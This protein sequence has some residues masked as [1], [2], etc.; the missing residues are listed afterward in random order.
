MPRVV[1]SFGDRGR[2]EEIDRLWAEIDALKKAPQ[3]TKSEKKT[4]AATNFLVGTE[5]EVRQSDQAVDTMTGVLEFD[6]AD[7]FS[8][9]QTADA[10]K[11]NVAPSLSGAAGGDLTGT[12]PNPTL[13]AIGTASGPIGDATHVAAVTKDAKGRVTGLSSVAISGVTPGGSAG[14]D[15]TG[16]YPNPALTTSGVSAGTYGDATNVPRV[17]FD[18][19]GRATSVSNIAISAGSGGYAYHVQMIVAN[20]ILTSDPTKIYVRISD[21]VTF[22]P[23]ITLPDPTSHTNAPIHFLSLNT[24][25]HAMNI[26]RHGSEKINGIAANYSMN[27]TGPRYTMFISNGTDWYVILSE[28]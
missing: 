28:L 7:G 3:A 5:I 19:K 1:N 10:I 8:L 26:L 13:A 16:T 12:Y 17:T 23:S 20:E 14:G 11:V 15:L 9:S 4:P 24:S 2:D 22:E 21:Q 18:A 25:T 6:Q 27:Q